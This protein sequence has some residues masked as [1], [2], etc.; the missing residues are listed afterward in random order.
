[1]EDTE[2]WKQPNKNGESRGDNVNT[3]GMLALSANGYKNLHLEDFGP[4]M[5]S[6]PAH[7]KALKAFH[8]GMKNGAPALY[9]LVSF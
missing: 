8:T 1:M 9:L 4:A 7:K 5:P 3:F 6:G 2:H